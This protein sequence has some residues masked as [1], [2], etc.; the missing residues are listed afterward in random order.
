VTPPRGASALRRVTIVFI[1]AWAVRSLIV[2]GDAVLH[3]HLRSTLVTSPWVTQASAGDGFEQSL[4][5]IRTSIPNSD[6]VD[7]IWTN[8][9][10]YYY[11][12]FWSTFWL[13]PRKVTV[14]GDFEP[15]QLAQ[16]DVLVYVRLPSV[17]SA[18]VNGF[19]VLDVYTFPD[20]IVT[21]YRRDG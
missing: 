21:T 2:S 13:F 11:A 10:D 6:R 9:P 17:P 18:D 1:T 8:P 7:V 4:V 15:A 3:E 12:F 14:L 19:T 20:Y 5:R 16:A